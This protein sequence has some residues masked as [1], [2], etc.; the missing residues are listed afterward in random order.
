MMKSIKK[1]YWLV[2]FL[3]I[4]SPLVAQDYAISNIPPELLE[5]AYAVVRLDES[6]FEV[7]SIKQGVF[8]K[9]V[10]YTILHKKANFLAKEVVPYNDLK[11]VKYLEAR[12]YDKYGKM[13][14]KL[15]KSD[16]KDQSAISGVSIYESSRVKIAELHHYDLPFTVEFEYETLNN[17]LLFY[18]SWYPQSYSKASVQSSKMEVIMPSG[19]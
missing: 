5:D 9:K 11:Q 16:I 2:I 17:N 19:I 7:Q 1:L 4:T 3:M 6:R 15:K 12:L 10:A 8:Y 13:I 18:P 14:K